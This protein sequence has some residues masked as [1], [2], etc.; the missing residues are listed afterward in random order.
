MLIFSLPELLVFCAKLLELLGCPRKKLGRG[1][2]VANIIV[3]WLLAIASW[4][5]GKSAVYHA[6]KKYSAAGRKTET[7]VG[8]LNTNGKVIAVGTERAD[9]TLPCC[10]LSQEAHHLLP[11]HNG[12]GAATAD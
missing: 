8:G 10:V 9:S 5:L 12:K 1:L 7:Y 6:C 4:A 3:V 2:T 11:S